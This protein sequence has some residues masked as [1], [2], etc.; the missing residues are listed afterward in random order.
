M[1]SVHVS[2]TPRLSRVPPKVSRRPSHRDETSAQQETP[3][4][5]PKV[6]RTKHHPPPHRWRVPLYTS[7][8]VV[9]GPF[10]RLE[11]AS[12][13]GLVTQT[14][15]GACV[16]EVGH[17]GSESC[18][19]DVLSLDGMRMKRLQSAAVRSCRFKRVGSWDRVGTRTERWLPLVTP[20]SVVASVKDSRF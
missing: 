15:V 16:A 5:A 17:R 2:R 8:H 19:S 12:R 14:A 1:H 18:A 7:A 6:S 4:T 10:K 13:G 9:C 20:R 11:W 3:P